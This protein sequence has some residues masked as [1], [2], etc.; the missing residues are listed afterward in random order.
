M[1]K[2]FE[3]ALEKLEEIVQKLEDGNISLDDSLKLFDEGMKLSKFCSDKLAEAE[4]K[5]EM[6][7]NEGNEDKVVPFIAEDE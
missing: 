7:L 5:V 2:K 6:I 4:K 3:D 1:A